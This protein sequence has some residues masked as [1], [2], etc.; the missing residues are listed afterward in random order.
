[1]SRSFE[2]TVPYPSPP[3]VVH[4]TL[5]EDRFWRSIFEGAENAS[6][7]IT[8]DGP[9]T[10]EVVM[11]EH[12]GRQH[13]PGPV[14]KVIKGD[15]VLSHTDRWGPFDGERAKGTFEG[16]SQGMNGRIDGTMQLRPDGEGSAIDVSGVVEVK[17][18]LV[19]GMLEA[20]VANM[21]TKG[22][23]GKRDYVEKWIAEQG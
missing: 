12:V 14:K 16:G 11:V 20:M 13:I 17:V 4:A 19:G 10:I 18:R 22:F 15:L 5:T 6:V 21:M 23:T 8:S 9:G 2:F 3:A 7:E 1:M